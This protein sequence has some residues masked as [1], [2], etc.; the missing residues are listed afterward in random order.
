MLIA[1]NQLMCDVIL[2]HIIA[3]LKDNT[4]ITFLLL[5]LSNTRIN[6]FSGPQSIH[7]YILFYEN[8]VHIHPV[9][10]KAEAFLEMSVCQCRYCPSFNKA[11]TGTYFNVEREENPQFLLYH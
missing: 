9:Q 8:S 4:Q 10:Y 3:V 7:I 1:S 6:N 2:F 5:E 11:N